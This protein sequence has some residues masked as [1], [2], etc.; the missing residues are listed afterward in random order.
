MQGF[1]HLFTK[2]DADP[3]IDS[4]Q[5]A[6]G[7]AGLVFRLESSQYEDDS[8]LYHLEWAWSWLGD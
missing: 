5:D 3:L 4:I 2:D 1:A 7:T 8:S 6:M